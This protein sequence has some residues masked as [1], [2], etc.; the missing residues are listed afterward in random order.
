MNYLGCNFS[1]LILIK[2]LKTSFFIFFK[3]LKNLNLTNRFLMNQLSIF[4]K[5]NRFSMIY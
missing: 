4:M 2:N 1:N 5:T 3:F